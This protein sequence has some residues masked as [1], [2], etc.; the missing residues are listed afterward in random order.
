VFFAGPDALSGSLIE[1]LKEVKPTFFFSVPRV[2]EKIEEK[3]KLT[4][5]SN[6]FLKKAIANWAKGLGK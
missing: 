5:S 3:M 1:T 4:A 6:G 2:W